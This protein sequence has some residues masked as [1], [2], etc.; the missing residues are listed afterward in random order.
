MIDSKRRNKLLEKAQISKTQNSYWNAIFELR[1]F[2]DSEMIVKCFEFINSNNEKLQII[3]IDILSQLG[4]NRKLFSK[5]LIKYIFELL[6]ISESQKL[7]T[8]C[9]IAISH[10]NTEL[11]NKQIL[12]LQKFKDSKSKEIRYSLVFSLSKIDNQHAI[13]TLIKLSNDKSPKIRDWSLFG[14]GT[15]IK[16][17]NIEIREVLYKH[18]F[19]KDN[20]AKQEAIKG[21]SNRKDK[22]VNEIILKELKTENFNS[23]FFETLMEIEGGSD[24]LPE[25]EN[26]YKKAKKDKKINQDW[27]ANLK[28]CISVLKL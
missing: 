16:T 27:L 9:L 25:L 17:D 28:N 8:S 19:D 23:S 20:Q 1:E 5:K 6:K 14:L 21:L 24:F 10:N 26:I 22:R 12:L 18:C 7:I 15:L 2:V 3:G 4:T 11:T 13:E